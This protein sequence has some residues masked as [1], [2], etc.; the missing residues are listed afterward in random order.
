MSIKAVMGR[1]QRR[2]ERIDE[3]LAMVRSH[4]FFFFF[5]VD[6]NRDNLAA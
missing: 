4:A 3:M 2:E 5:E 1:V 6:D